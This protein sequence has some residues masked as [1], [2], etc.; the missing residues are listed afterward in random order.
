ME[1]A[2]IIT[3]NSKIDIQINGEGIFYKSSVQ[4]VNSDYIA[5]H[6]PSHRGS[7]VYLEP[8]DSVKGRVYSKDAQYLFDS[9]VLGKKLDRVVLFLL[10]VPSKLK[11]VQMRDYVRVQTMVPVK[12]RI[13]KEDFP[14]QDSVE[15]FKESYTLDISGGGLHFNVQGPV[16]LNSLIELEL[17]ITD[18]KQKDVKI[19][20]LA[21]VKRKEPGRNKGQVSLG[22]FFEEIWE[23]DRDILIGFLF[24]K[25]LKQRRLGVKK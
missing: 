12:Y 20:A 18:Q 16:A 22:V 25:L 19:R 23:K 15:P 6:I 10:A 8:G 11:R 4:E 5:I 9:T 3:I 7:V 24:R 2:D 1:V 21:R 14:E 13:L 17:T